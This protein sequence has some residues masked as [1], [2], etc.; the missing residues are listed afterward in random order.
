M[1]FAEDVRGCCLLGDRVISLMMMVDLSLLA[2][3]VWFAMRLLRAARQQDRPSSDDGLHPE[4]ATVLIDLVSEPETPALP[5]GFALFEAENPM[6]TFAA[7]ASISSLDQANQDDLY[8]DPIDGVPFTAGE[9]IHTCR[10]GVGYRQESLQWI[11]EN[12]SGQC[13][14]CGVAID[15][16]QVVAVCHSGPIGVRAQ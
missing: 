2:F 7:E 1:S 10:C 16:L 13:V 11:E 9:E 15:A 5:D 14:H 4:F 6:L 3:A 8:A 12:L